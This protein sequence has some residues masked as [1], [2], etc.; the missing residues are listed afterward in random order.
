MPGP[1]QA[2]YTIVH[3]EGDLFIIRVLNEEQVEIPYGIDRK[4]RVWRMR[5][6]IDFGTA[7]TRMA[8]LTADG[9]VYSGSAWQ[10]IPGILALSCA[11]QYTSVRRLMG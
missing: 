11:G 10:T 5:L 9:L 2:D 7:Y 4:F 8:A 6:G 1:E 3:E